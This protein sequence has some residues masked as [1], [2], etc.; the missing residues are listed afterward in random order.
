MNWTTFKFYRG[1]LTGH[2]AERDGVTY[3]IVPTNGRPGSFD[4]L[5]DGTW[6]GETF[7]SVEAAKAWF[8]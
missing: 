8:A 2:R 3:E 7:P 4:V 6:V 5:A 1:T